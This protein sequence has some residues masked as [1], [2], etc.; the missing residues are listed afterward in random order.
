MISPIM[1]E[2]LQGE[3]WGSDAKIFRPERFLDENGKLKFDE[4][5]V[6]FSVGKRRCLGETL[7]KIELFQFFSGIMQNFTILPED[8]DNLPSEEYIMGVTITP[9]P[10]KCILSPRK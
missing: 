7:A 8:P 2:I 10:F 1:V 4:H 3:H 9:K 5:L 6:P